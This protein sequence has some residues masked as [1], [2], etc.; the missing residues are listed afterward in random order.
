[1]TRR[2][3]LAPRRAPDIVDGDTTAIVR[4]YV[5][6]QQQQEEEQQPV[7]PCGAEAGPWAAVA[8]Q[9]RADL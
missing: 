8:E 2:L 3:H 5:L 9:P 1:M 4:P 7:P 6:A